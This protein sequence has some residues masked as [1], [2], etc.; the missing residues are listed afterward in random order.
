MTFLPATTKADEIDLSAA[1]N[2]VAGAVRT[3]RVMNP[4]HE[5]EIHSR[6]ETALLDASIY[7]TREHKLA[8]RARIDFLTRHGIGIEVKRGKPLSSN[9]AAQLGRYIA[10]DS[11]RGIVVVV[12]RNIFNVP[13][14]INGKPI[15]YISLSHLWGIAL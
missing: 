11:V 12:D 6:I 8:K 3:I 5:F 2:A 4:D 15:L 9:V 13:S 14:E 1:M 7:F 10:C